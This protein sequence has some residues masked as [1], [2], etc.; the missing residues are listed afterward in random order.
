MELASRAVL[1]AYGISYQDIESWGGKI[2]FRALRPS[3]EMMKEGR[4]D[5]ISV[6]MQFP[7]PYLLDISRTHPL[8]LLSLSKQATRA[9]NAK[10]GT[11]A[12]VIPANS[13]S[14]VQQDVNTLSDIVLLIGNSHLSQEMAYAVSEALLRNLPY[15]HRV[16]RALA[17]LKP[18]DLP[19]VGHVPLH[20]GARASYEKAGVLQ[21]Q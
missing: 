7:H 1:E 10:L 4:L 19:R 5:A 21:P 18:E 17:R 15:L 9:V 16:H 3:L 6:T 8:R 14:F 11:Y 20:P 13:Y 2:Y 12:S